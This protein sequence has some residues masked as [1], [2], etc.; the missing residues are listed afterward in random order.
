MLPILTVAP[1][2]A[3]RRWRSLRDTGSVDH[4]EQPNSL[5]VFQTE[6]KRDDYGER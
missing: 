6:T 5:M 3:P 4:G 1:N 2:N